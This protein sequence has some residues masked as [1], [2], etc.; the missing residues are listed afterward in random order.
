VSAGQI[1]GLGLVLCG[2]L[3]WFLVPLVVRGTDP[4]TPAAERRRL[5]SFGTPW[6]DRRRA[7][8]PWS[9]RIAAA[10]FVVVGLLMLAGVL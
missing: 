7:V 8:Y 6:S 3:V 10:V 9:R 2:V 1:T 4:A 5:G